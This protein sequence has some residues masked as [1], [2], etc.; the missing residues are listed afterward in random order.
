MEKQWRHAPHGACELKLHLLCRIKS[1]T[2]VTLPTERVSWNLRQPPKVEQ[3]A[4]H[5]PHGACELKFALF[6]A[7]FSSLCHAPH[8]A[9]ELKLI[10]WRFSQQHFWSRSPR[11]VWVEIR[12]VRLFSWKSP[13]RSPRSVWVEIV[14]R[15]F[16]FKFCCCHAPHGACELKYFECNKG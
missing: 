14:Y 8:G 10:L 15:D 2:K 13:S 9:C 5:A 7:I 1:A 12:L 6:S 4:R 16:N 3:F 11:S